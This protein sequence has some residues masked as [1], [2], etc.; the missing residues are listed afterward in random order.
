MKKLLSID[1]SCALVALRY[2]SGIDEDTMER[3][4]IANNF[5]PGIGMFDEDWKKV[6]KALGIKIR[7]ALIE[8]GTLRKFVK[9]HPEGLYL[10]CTHD[11]IFVVDNGVV[12]DPKYPNALKLKRVIKEAWLVKK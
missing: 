3:L 5:K 10:V 7:S 8:V 9:E 4:C 6:A 12:F 2:I 1:G 11:H